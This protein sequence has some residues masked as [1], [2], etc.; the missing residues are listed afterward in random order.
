MA[1]HCPPGLEHLEAPGSAGSPDGALGTLLPV[2]VSPRNPLLYAEGPHSN[3]YRPWSCL[4]SLQVT[5]VR[6]AQALSWLTPSPGQSPQ[7]PGIQPSQAMSL[8]PV[9]ASQPAGLVGV[10]PVITSLSLRFFPSRGWESL[11]P[12]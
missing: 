4:V 3:F 5:P 12:S 8:L 1:A 6:A 11:A 2:E 10:L 7:D 9:E